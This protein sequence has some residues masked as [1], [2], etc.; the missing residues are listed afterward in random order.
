MFSN[1]GMAMPS[2]T[3]VVDYLIRVLWVKKYGC[4]YIYIYIY[5]YIYL[6][7]HR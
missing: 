5:I 1:F 2:D 4:L 6:Y 3:G 7:I